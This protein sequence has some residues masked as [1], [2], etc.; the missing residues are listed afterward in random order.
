MEHQWHIRQL[1]AANPPASAERM[2]GRKGNNHGFVC[3][4]EAT[5]ARAVLDGR[6]HEGD[7]Q[8]GSSESIDVLF[9]APRLRDDFDTRV[10]PLELGRHMLR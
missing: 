9:G 8:L 10:P 7:I 4:L 6:Q 2:S 3:N 5:N 1:A